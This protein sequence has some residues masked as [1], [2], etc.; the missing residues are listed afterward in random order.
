MYE[1][2]RGAGFG[3]A[4]LGFLASIFGSAFAS[5]AGFAMLP[6]AIAD[7]FG[8]GSSTSMRSPTPSP[9]SR[10]WHGSPTSR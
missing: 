7:F 2:T 8:A 5:A 4:T 1:K 9:P 3:F 10:S 6:F